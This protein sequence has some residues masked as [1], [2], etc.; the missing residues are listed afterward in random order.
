MQY[1]LKRIFCVSLMSIFCGCS[2]SGC[3]NQQKLANEANI[4]SQQ[5]QAQINYNLSDVNRNAVKAQKVGAKFNIENKKYVNLKPIRIPAAW[6]TKQVAIYASNQPLSS[7]VTEMT[8][9]TN[10]SNVFQ[11][12]MRNK[13]ISVFYRGNLYNGL[14]KIADDNDIVFNIDG[15]VNHPAFNWSQYETKT[16]QIA[17]LPGNTSFDI[18]DYSRG[19]ANASTDTS[20]SAQTA[21]S[22]GNSSGASLSSS[23]LSVWK[24]ITSTVQGMLTAQGKL[25]VSQASSSITVIDT[26]FAV[27][28]ITK[29]IDHYNS[30]LSNRVAIKVKILEVQLDNN[31]ASGIDWNAV[32]HTLGSTGTFTGG[33]GTGVIGNFSKAVAGGMGINIGKGRWKDSSLLI[34]A[35]DQQGKTTV[36][37]EPTVV[38]L[39]N[40]P[41]TI[42]IGQN[43]A[44][45]QKTDVTMDAET[46]TMTTAYTP[47]NIKTG[48]DLTIIPHIQDNKIYLSLNAILSTL[49]G[50][51]TIGGDESAS[52]EDKM[53]N[54]SQI[55]LPQTEDRV[56]NQRI[57]AHNHNV[58]VLSGFKV[59][60]NATQDNKN[61][62]VSVLGGNYGLSSN[63]E[64]VVLIQPTIIKRAM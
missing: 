50:I 40:Q 17:F 11:P 38:S 30:M 31:H 3:A 44:Y 32:L 62:G 15:N 10:V 22:K 36:I 37:N 28:K 47:G 53:K 23:S 7:V 42:S 54:L 51:K 27:R 64:L 24:D 45:V 1:K 25:S 33:F 48:L 39:N 59:K 41:N 8:K 46:H 55:Q 14:K 16:F 12:Q 49:Q 20:D 13:T 63:I 19:G 43:Q 2:L 52:G 57:M 9:G 34:K 29:F 4:A 60:Q 35:L 58:I 21:L 18:G 6:K 61:F 26:P 56:F 5:A